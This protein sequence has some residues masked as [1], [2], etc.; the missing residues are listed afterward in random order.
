MKKKYSQKMDD[1]PL[2]LQFT[3]SLIQIVVLLERGKILSLWNFSTSQRIVSIHIFCQWITTLNVS[4]EKYFLDLDQDTICN[5]F[6]QQY[7]QWERCVRK[8][9]ETFIFSSLYEEKKTEKC[10]CRSRSTV[11]KSCMPRTWRDKMFLLSLVTPDLQLRSSMTISIFI[12]Y[13]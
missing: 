13:Y 2:A 6:I 8:K 11:R 9:N 4:N 3:E 1:H 7:D 10:W 5:S 12:R